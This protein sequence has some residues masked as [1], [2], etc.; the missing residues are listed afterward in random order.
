M[1]AGTGSGAGRLRVVIVGG[2]IAGAEALLALRH[3]LG[4]RVEIELV[5][6]ERRFVHRPVALA[7][8]F[9]LGEGRPLDLGALAG[10]QGVAFI[11]DVLAEVDPGRK[12]ALLRGGI[13]LPYDALLLA[14]G[15]HGVEQL[16]GALTYDGGAPANRA[17][18][19]LLGEL[20]EGRSRRVVFAVPTGLRW[21]LPLYE[22]ALLTAHHA[23]ERDL[24]IELLLAGEE[25]RPL[26]M[27]GG[28]ASEALAALL[29]S[30][31]IEFRGAQAPGAVRPEGLALAGG[32]LIEADRVVAL[33]R[34]EVAPIPGVPQ[35]PS[36]FIGTDLQM[37]VEG[38]DGVYAAGDATW[39]PVKQGGIAAQQADVV[40]AAI[41][42]DI[43][44]A[45]PNEQFRPVLRGALLT[46]AAPLYLRAG[47]GTDREASSAA[48]V[49]P[50]WW[51]PAK[52]AARHLAPYLGGAGEEARLADLPPL[53]GEDPGES[54]D[55][56][57]EAVE[58][59]L[60]SADADA[61]WRDYAGALRWLDLAEQLA[62]T[63]PPG[64]ARKRRD[65]IAAGSA[66]TG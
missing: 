10:E 6:R 13:E 33:P 19:E 26:E 55:D 58:L 32:E 9:G 43:D 63:L 31:G 66:A 18:R 15:A 16:P 59:A 61:R 24:D 25:E 48:G 46:G 40:A 41:A 50:L 11:E 22:L 42:A 14:I 38:L 54:G 3:L 37:R 60:A 65:W 30:A 53:E 20:E 34:L 62:L 12:V 44:P 56:H 5:A 36:G 39:F 64:Y 52:V 45:I 28:R 27:F 4:D 57:R 35:G 2:G 51:P 23:D 47:L 1:G 29:D 49:A 17:Y 21:A 7:E 8:P